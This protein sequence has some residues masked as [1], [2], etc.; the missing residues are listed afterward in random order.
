VKRLHLAIF[1]FVLAG[2]MA[3]CGIDTDEVINDLNN[4]LED[5]GEIYYD[6][7][8]DDENQDGWCD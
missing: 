5:E 2:S 1:I 3:A 4:Q 6:P 8:C 7:S